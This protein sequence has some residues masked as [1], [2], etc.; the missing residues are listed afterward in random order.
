[1]RMR[2]SVR[3]K[4]GRAFCIISVDIKTHMEAKYEF[5]APSYVDF[6]AVREGNEED[7]DVDHWF[8]SK[9]TTHHL[10]FEQ[11]HEKR[12]VQ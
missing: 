9:Y 10:F 6:E 5:D 2:I 8:S 7:D 1:M 4:S 12:G 3:L 11:Q